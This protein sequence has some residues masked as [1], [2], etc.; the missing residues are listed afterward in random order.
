MDERMERMERMIEEM[1]ESMKLMGW[2]IDNASHA[3]QGMQEE[4]EGM[5]DWWEEWEEQ[6]DAM[7]MYLDYG[8]QEF[9]EEF[10]EYRERVDEMTEYLEM[11][12]ISVHPQDISV[13]AFS[14]MPSQH[15]HWQIVTKQPCHH[16]QHHPLPYAHWQPLIPHQPP[17][18]WP[19]YLHQ[20][21]INRVSQ[22]QHH[23]L[24]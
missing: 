19:P 6:L 21:L 13:N 24:T 9:G 20:L 7:D 5:Q 17:A 18:H 23:S 16:W 8:W 3:Q 12:S 1:R 22:L 15:S 11:V 14:S 4:I 10:V 2:N